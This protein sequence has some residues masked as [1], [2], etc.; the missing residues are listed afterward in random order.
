MNLFVK[1]VLLF[2]VGVVGILFLLEYSFNQYASQSK[3]Y[4]LKD[5]TTTL[6]AGNSRP[7]CA[8]N[9]S[10]ISNT[11]NIAAVAEPYFYTYIKLRKLLAANPGIQNVFVELGNNSLLDSAMNEWVYGK[12]AIQ[13]LYPKYAQLMS[14]QEKNILLQNNPM[15]FLKSISLNFKANFILLSS[16]STNALKS[17]LMGGYTAKTG[18]HIFENIN[19]K[20]QVADHSSKNS[21]AEFNLSYLDKIVVLCKANKR[22]IYFIQSPVH[23]AYNLTQSNR[24]YDSILEHRYRGIKL[25]DFSKFQMVDADYFDFH[26]LNS[27]GA[28][29]VSYAMD[30]ILLLLKSNPNK[31][32]Y[33]TNRLE[34]SK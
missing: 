6:I 5:G 2:L 17:K 20:K 18:S 19:D 26:H 27:D 16:R 9:D 33:Q 25:L 7:E 10:I 13:Y 3:Y 12:G 22:N 31:L 11:V 15:E 28:R 29:K 14:F 1:R 32:N 23:P 4:V 21:L 24:L 34:V 30:S 8:F